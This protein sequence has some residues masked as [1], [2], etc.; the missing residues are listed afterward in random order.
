MFQPAWNPLHGAPTYPADRYGTLADRIGRLLNTANDVLLVQ[1]EAVV[2]LEAVA[3]SLARP[4]LAALNIVTSPYGGWFGQWLRRGGADIAD[5]V[6]APGL[7]IEVEAIARAL[8]A[9]PRIRLLALVHAESASG[10]LN[11]LPEI[12][13]LAHGR[14]IVTVVD[15]V[16]SVG[17]HALDVDTL[18]I[19]I[20]VI[21]PQKALGG[22]A[23][24]SALRSVRA[25]GA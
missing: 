7:P 21:G 24:V 4:G 2:A 5:V 11:P 23:G 15:A 13:D 10:I 14:G 16:A 17:G 9:N 22:P 12:L 19:D 25:P 6:A 1:A 3:A 20:A 18:G 8:D